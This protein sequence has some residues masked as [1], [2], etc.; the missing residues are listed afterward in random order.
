MKKP[1]KN[2]KPKTKGKAK[3]DR[4]EP[5][6]APKTKE[7]K[8]RQRDSCVSRLGS[9]SR[10]VLTWAA[11]FLFG[12]AAGSLLDFWGPLWPTKPIVNVGEPSF[13]RAFELPFFVTNKSALFDMKNTTIRCSPSFLLGTFGLF[14]VGGPA[15]ENVT[16][17][18]GD[19][20]RSF[21]CNISSDVDPQSLSVEFNFQYEVNLLFISWTREVRS[22]YF[23]W[24]A[25][26]RPPRWDRSKPL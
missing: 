12:H 25:E 6:K 2:R 26:A 8:S 17:E 9:I 5:R 15:A 20:G 18:A 3:K 16:I 13:S 24:N 11:L 23:T 1:P 4:S 22:D 7:P 14:A 21:I 19:H 10:R